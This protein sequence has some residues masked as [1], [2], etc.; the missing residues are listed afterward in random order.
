L[1]HHDEDARDPHLP[2]LIWWGIESKAVSDREQVLELFNSPDSYQHPILRD[3][4]MGR[5]ARR[6][7]AQPTPENLAA[8]AALLE[9]APGPAERKILLDGVSEAFAG[10]SLSALPKE[11]AQ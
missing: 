2:L 5:L 8:V 1:A 10:R 9:R 6:Y 4:V 3:T 7:A 11:V